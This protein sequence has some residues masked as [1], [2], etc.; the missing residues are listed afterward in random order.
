MGCLLNNKKTIKRYFFC[1]LNLVGF[2]LAGIFSVSADVLNDLSKE[3]PP[4]QVQIEV[5]VA[6]I[7]RDDDFEVGMLHEFRSRQDGSVSLYNDRFRTGSG[8]EYVER[9]QS[10]D[11]G[12][13]TARFPL[14]ESSDELYQ[15]LD[16]TG[17][18]LD[19]SAGRL[20]ATFQA[21]SS[22]NRGEILARPSVVVIDGQQAIIETGQNVP[23][24]TRKV[25][26]SR[27]VFVSEYRRTGI[28]LVVTPQ[29]LRDD[30]GYYYVQLNVN[31]EV[32][33][34]S[35]RR[36]EK[37]ILLPVV[38]TRNANTTVLV[39]SGK[40]FIMGGLFRDNETFTENGIPGVSK[41]P[42]IGGLFRSRSKSN[43]KSEL[44]I[45]L[46]PTVLT[47]DEPEQRRKTTTPVLGPEEQVIPEKMDMK[48]LEGWGEV[49]K[50]NGRRRSPDRVPSATDEPLDPGLNAEGGV[51]P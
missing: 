15:G 45:S 35:R 18:L 26:N 50:K 21:L 9:T 22:V 8:P 34:V 31:P 3:A 28:K 38:A 16:V 17:Q 7:T 40:T 6:D 25:I 23:F 20:L 37:G 41:I 12:D 49:K 29:V 2:S 10:G 32:S 1:Y 51:R 39:A 19:V 48:L 5:L 47:S 24:L 13:V 44:I 30:D 4:F 11:L 14:T 43:L 42:V 46:T 33:F 36:E 27:E